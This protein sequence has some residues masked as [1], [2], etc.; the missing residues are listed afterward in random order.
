MIA[1]GDDCCLPSTATLAGDR[2]GLGY[3]PGFMRCRRN[4]A[5]ASFRSESALSYCN[6]RCLHN[7]S[8]ACFFVA[9]SRWPV[10]CG[11]RSGTLGA[12]VVIAAASSGPPPAR[13][14]DGGH[15][16]RTADDGALECERAS[17]CDNPT[18]R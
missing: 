15:G 13:R 6:S 2:V 11:G 16:E 5:A 7:V 17:G 18:S 14:G 4:C 12:D 8:W 10:R 9:V 1:G 3:G